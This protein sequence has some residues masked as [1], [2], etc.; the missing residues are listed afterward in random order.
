[1]IVQGRNKKMN[2]NLRSQIIYL[3]AKFVA[4]ILEDV[5]KMF[6]RALSFL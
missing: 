6:R 2:V 3:R 1:M 5:K 4:E